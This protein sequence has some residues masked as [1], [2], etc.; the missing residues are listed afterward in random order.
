VSG[1]TRR[2]SILRSLQGRSD[3]LRNAELG[4]VLRP[5][6]E[7]EWIVPTLNWVAIAISAGWG[8]YGGGYPTPRCLRHP[9]TGLVLLDG[10]AECTGSGTQP[11]QIGVLPAGY[12]PTSLA[13]LVGAASLPFVG[14]VVVGL[15]VATSGALVLRMSPGQTTVNGPIGWCSLA[16]CSFLVG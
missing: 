7:V 4:I 8:S 2:Y 3:R 6:P 15:D 13:P 10:M 14:P 1:V 5:P 16:G 9:E 11:A 12:R